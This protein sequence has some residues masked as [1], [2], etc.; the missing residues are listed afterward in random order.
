M[1]IYLEVPNVV[2]WLIGTNFTSFGSFFYFVGSLLSV[3][4]ICDVA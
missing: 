2:I 3:L 1:T 4:D